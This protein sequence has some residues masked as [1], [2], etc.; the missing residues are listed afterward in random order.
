M[1]WWLLH[2]WISPLRQLL[3]SVQAGAQVACA[4]KEKGQEQ[5]VEVNQLELGCCREHRLP[6]WV[7]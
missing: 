2:A 4:A 1:S 3:G 5:N 6:V 7:E